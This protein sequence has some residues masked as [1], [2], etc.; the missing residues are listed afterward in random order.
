MRA[1]LLGL[2]W[3]MTVSVHEAKTHL[4]RLLQSIAAGEDVTI[5]PSGGP[6]ARLVLTPHDRDPFYRVLVAQAQIEG[7]MLVT[8]DLAFS[9]YDVRLI[10]VGARQRR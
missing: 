1:F 7:L 3:R 8:A 5:T 10:Q 6:V 9:H 4:S 2:D